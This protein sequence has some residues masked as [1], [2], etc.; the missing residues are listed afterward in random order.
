MQDDHEDSEYIEEQLRITK[1]SLAAFTQ[2]HRELLSPIEHFIVDSLNADP[3]D[4]SAI[5]HLR[6]VML[7]LVSFYLS[8]FNAMVNMNTRSDL[9]N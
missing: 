8:Q 9:I 6:H 1:E 5:N 3:P 4:F 7:T 2:K